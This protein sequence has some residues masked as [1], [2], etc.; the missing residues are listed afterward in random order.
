MGAVLDGAPRCVIIGGSNSRAI[1]WYNVKLNAIWCNFISLVKWF[2]LVPNNSVALCTVLLVRIV[3]VLGKMFWR[4]FKWLL[5]MY[6]FP[7]QS[8]TTFSQPTC[9]SN[10]TPLPTH[11]PRGPQTSHPSHQ[12]TPSRTQSRHLAVHTN[13]NSAFQ[14]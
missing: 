7:V 1:N 4:S 12:H 2:I 3:P 10:I 11:P 8:L 14:Y 13:P 5:A 9:S 6:S